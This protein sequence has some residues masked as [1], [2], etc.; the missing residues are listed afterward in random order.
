M[1]TLQLLASR[2][3]SMQQAADWVQDHLESPG[4][5][6]SIC[7]EF[8]INSAMLAEIV[9]PFVPGAVAGDV[10]AFFTTLG[11][12][13]QVLRNAG[14]NPAA[15]LPAP[16]SSSE[17][18]APGFFPQEYAALLSFAALNHNAGA[19]SN[20]SLREASFA[21][22]TQRGD[23]WSLFSPAQFGGQEGGSWS[24]SELGLPG[25]GDLPATAETL[26]SL[27]YGTVIRLVRSVDEQ[28]VVGLEAFVQANEAALEAGHTATVST[29]IQQ[30]GQVFST[31]AVVPLVSDHE[32]AALFPFV[33]ASMVQLVGTGNPDVFGGLLDFVF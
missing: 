5:I 18:V 6:F 25:L 9:Q 21:Q 10:E 28:E 11:F 20:D 29:L 23:Y 1:N 12:D 13:A 26:E 16:G 19:L 8:G 31:P 4:Q 7:L 17:I 15:P 27:F 30:L 24:A 32:L 14:I 3:V 22:G 2:G 33:T